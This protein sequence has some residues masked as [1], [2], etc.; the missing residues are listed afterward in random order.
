MPLVIGWR[1]EAGDVDAESA[2]ENWHFVK[3]ERG[4]Y[5][6]IA[7]Q[8]DSVT[9]NFIA[10]AKFDTVAAARTALNY[11]AKTIPC[12]IISVQGGLQEVK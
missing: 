11:G 5:Y 1:L 8:A 7:M 9:L 2:P 10:C 6:L 3:D 12:S 4:R